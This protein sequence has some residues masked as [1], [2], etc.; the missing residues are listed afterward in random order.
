MLQVR[1]NYAL[2]A[3]NARTLKI[4]LGLKSGDAKMG[5]QPE[6]KAPLKEKDF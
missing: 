4:G 6:Q 3:K 1:G 5:Y 2:N